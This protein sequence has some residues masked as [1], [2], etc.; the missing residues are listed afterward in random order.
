MFATNEELHSGALTEPGAQKQSIRS[1]LVGFHELANLLK[2]ERALCLVFRRRA[3][4][5]EV[6]VEEDLSRGGV[7][8]V[9]NRVDRLPEPML[10]G[11]SREIDGDASTPVDVRIWA[12]DQ[13]LDRHVAGKT[14]RGNRS[15]RAPAARLGLEFEVTVDV[16]KRAQRPSLPEAHERAELLFDLREVALERLAKWESFLRWKEWDE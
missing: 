7:T 2:V 15:A 5:A 14:P 8:A 12:P 13:L 6:D 4:D 9:R 10:A 1:E 3:R 16:V 11:V